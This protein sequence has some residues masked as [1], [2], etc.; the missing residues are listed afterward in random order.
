[1]KALKIFIRMVGFLVCGLMASSHTQAQDRPLEF[2]IVPQQ[3]ASK[4]AEQWVPLLKEVSRRSGV[5]LVFRTDVSIPVFIQH[6][7]K[8]EYDIAYL[9]PYNYVV[10]HTSNGYRAFA[11]E[12]DRKLKGIVVVKKDSRYQQLSDLAG[13]TV[14]F[15][16]PTSFA[17]SILPQVEFGRQKINIEAQFVLSHD[18]VYRAVA[19]GLQ[20]AGGGIE[21]TLEAA[22]AEVRDKLRIISETQ[23]FTPHAFAAHP[24]VSKERVAKVMAAFASLSD[25]EIGRKLLEPLAFKGIVP[26]DDH[27]W[28]DIRKLDMTLLGHYSHL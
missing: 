26:A 7:V 28:N 24:R 14:V 13:K 5:E 27:D 11:K 25:D 21:R 8:D 15:P 23:S 18:S 10:L 9:N 4:L 1:M 20:E 2:G 17:A 19:S 16:A 22:P 3:A 6:L 12:K